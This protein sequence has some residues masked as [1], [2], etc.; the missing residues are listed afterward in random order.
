MVL[1]LLGNSGNFFGSQVLL[2]LKLFRNKA[3]ICSSDG[4][5]NK[6]QKKKKNIPDYVSYHAFLMTLSFR[7]VKKW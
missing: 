2:Y 3:M 1:W 6:T 5:K 7:S 4:T